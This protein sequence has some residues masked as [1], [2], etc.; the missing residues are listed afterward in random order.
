MPV[1][2]STLKTPLVIFVSSVSMVVPGLVW[3]QEMSEWIEN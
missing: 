3:A 2:H 1:L